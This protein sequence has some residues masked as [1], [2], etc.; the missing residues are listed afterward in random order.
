M[1]HRYT[2]DFHTSIASLCNVLCYRS[3]KCGKSC[4]RN[5]IS[6][7]EEARR[8]NN[9]GSADMPRNYWTRRRCGK[10]GAGKHE[11]AL[12]VLTDLYPLI[13][14]GR[15]FFGTSSLVKLSLTCNRDMCCKVP[16]I[17]V[18]ESISTMTY[19]SVREK[20]SVKQDCRSFSFEVRSRLKLRKIRQVDW[21]TAQ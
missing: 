11:Q 1:L 21:L 17:D 13:P 18:C 4:S 9:S 8:R 16:T 6:S 19:G 15:V 7:S 2:R 14:I 10:N 3:L 12:L 20:T 5:W